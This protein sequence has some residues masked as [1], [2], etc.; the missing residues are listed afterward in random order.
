VLTDIFFLVCAKDDRSHL[1]TLARIS[2]MLLRPTMLEELRSADTPEE[3]F[4]ILLAAEH[5]ILGH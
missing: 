1:R 4:E 2:R 3:T 5:E